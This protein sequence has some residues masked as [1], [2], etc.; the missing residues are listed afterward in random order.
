M[1]QIRKYRNHPEEAVA[2]IA[3]AAKKSHAE[4][5]YKNLTANE[6]LLFETAKKKELSC[7][8]DTNTVKAI[9][10]S[11]IHPSRIMGS[12]W[13]LTWKTCDVSSTGYKAKARLVVKG[14]QDPEVG[15]AQTDSP[16]LSRDARMLLLQTVAS[17]GWTIQNFDI[18]TAFLRGKEDGRELAMNPVPELRTLMNLK[19]D[20]VC[21]LEG[22][23]YGR[24]DAP[25]L[26]YKELRKQLEQLHL[27]PI[28]L[29]TAYF[30]Y[31][32][33]RTLRN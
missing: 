8:L 7:R 5:S 28:L 22:N 16:T 4:V 26:F 21:L 14:F 6:R 32:I 30:F 27:K 33:P 12:R 13:V 23:A 29:I 19:D 9:A 31:E 1:Q 24:V 2:L 25:I 20:E 15:S 10:K 17:K 18:R 3:N 11:R